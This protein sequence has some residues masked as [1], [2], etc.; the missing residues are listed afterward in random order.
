MGLSE[1]LA[2]SGGAWSHI[3]GI[4]VNRHM[5]PFKC[6]FNQFQYPTGLKRLQEG[7]TCIQHNF[8]HQHNLQGVQINLIKTHLHLI[9]KN[10]G[11]CGSFMFFFFYLVF[12]MPLCASVYVCLVVTCWERTDLLALVCGLTVS[13]LLSHWYP[14]SGVVLDCIDS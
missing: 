5:I 13:L 6:R 11:F 2:T 12:V 8:F 14:G 3:H 9:R 1:L 7:L 10:R 4:P